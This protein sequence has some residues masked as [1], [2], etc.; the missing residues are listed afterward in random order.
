MAISSSKQVFGCCVLMLL[1]QTL[2]QFRRDQRRAMEQA[3]LFLRS[4]S[5][6][7]HHQHRRHR[8]NDET[9]RGLERRDAAVHVEYGDF[10]YEK[11]DWDGSPIVLEEYK[12]VFFTVAKVGCT[13]FKMLFRRMM[14]YQDWNATDWQKMLP[15][16]PETNGLKYLY[17][18]SPERATE[19][20]TSPKWTRAIFVRDPKERFLSA[21]LDK[22]MNHETYLR[23]Q[24]C[25]YSGD[26]VEQARQS[27]HGFLSVARICDDAHWIP[28]SSRMEARFWPFINFVGRMET[29][30]D[31]TERLL[32]QIGAWDQFGKSGW[33]E[34]DGALFATKTGE[35][36]R[37]HA[38]DARNKLKQYMTPELEKEVDEY[39]ANDYSNK[40]LGLKKLEVFG[41]D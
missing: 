1:A 11:G 25:S 28:Q 14:G 38:T 40:K 23:Q 5:S 27:L 33:G 19:I 3:A 22:V 41:D 16:N 15:W 17:D 30:T 2:F 29:I 24:C 10:I 18:F 12:L 35:L 26:C 34:S 7:G 39:Y 8:A 21:F 31:N 6:A 20:M 32:K 36:G 4:T 13:Q 37:K 9:K